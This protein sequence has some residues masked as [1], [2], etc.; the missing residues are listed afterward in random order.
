MSKTKVCTKCGKKKK[1]TEFS[2]DKGQSSGLRPECRECVS[3]YYYKNKERINKKNKEWRE[4]NKKKL[5][6]K[7]LKNKYNITTKEYKKLK[8]D[9]KNSCAICGKKET[10]KTN[11][12]KT[13]RLSIDHDHETGKVRGLLCKNCNSVLGYIKED[14]LLLKNM[15]KYLIK[16]KNENT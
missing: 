11:N 9:Q 1:I 7:D 15:I 3:K 2:K 13:Q 12:G 16:H 6:E 14:I 4:K 8:K 5:R 10:R